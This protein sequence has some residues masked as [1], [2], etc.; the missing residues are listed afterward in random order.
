MVN[1]PIYYDTLLVPDTERPG[2]KIR[3]YKLLLKISMI[4][5]NKDLISESIIYQFKEEIG[6][7]KGKPL[8]SDTTLHALMSKNFRKMIDRYK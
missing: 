6:E 4:N 3:V 7:T 8:I 2:K 1:S 5:L